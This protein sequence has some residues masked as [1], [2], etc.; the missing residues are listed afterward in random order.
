LPL[1]AIG[2]RVRM[3][4]LRAQ[5]VVMFAERSRMARELHD[6]LLQGMSAVAM[7]LN[8]IRM[9]LSGAPEGPRRELE[10][11]QET[12]T[13]CLEETRRMVWDLRDRG[14]DGGDLGAALTRFAR[15][16]TQGTELACQ[17]SVEGGPA[18]LPHAIEDQLFR[19]GQEALTNAVKHAKANKIDVSL[20]YDPTKVTLT[21]SDDGAGFDPAVA[22]AGG[23]HFGLVGLRER[24]AAIRAA[25]DIR[26]APGQGT[27]IQVVMTR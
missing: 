1:I 12:V 2:H 19:I 7:Q 16:A 10:L 13:R 23:D 21:I 15:R 11:V 8:S 5:Y 25:L 24:A 18:H 22:P 27:T 14:A 17:V 9:R 3:A 4:R 6:T 20:H 26:S